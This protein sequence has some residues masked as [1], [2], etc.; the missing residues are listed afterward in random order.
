MPRPLFEIS[1]R[2]PDTAARTGMIHTTHGTIPTPAF[3]PV[4][5]QATVKSLAPKDLALLGVAIVMSNAY[6]LALRPGAATVEALGGLHALAGWDGP[7]MTDSGGFQ[8]FSLETKTQV[9]TDGVTFRSHID[10]SVQRF[11]PESV[12]AWQMTLGADLV[13]PLDVCTGYPVTH[14][15]A[16]AEMWLTRAWAERARRAHSRVGQVLYGIVQG[17]VFPDLRAESAR[18]IAAL[19]FEAY[20][21]GG[22]S[23]GETKTEMWSAVDAAL[24]HLPDAAPR[25]LLGV[26]YPEDL[27]EGVARGID[28]FDCVM[29]TRIARNAGALTMDGRI[30][31]RNSAFAQ[32]RRPL[33]E[34]CT[35]YACQHFSRG[36]IRHFT[37]ADEI[38]G[39]HLLTLHN[40]HFTL[41]LMRQLRGAIAAGSF[42][43]FR[44]DFLARYAG[45]AF[46]DPRGETPAP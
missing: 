7:M 16:A 28:T 2:D 10:G 22:V 36:A 40:L 14:E 45:G 42:A 6:H 29:P 17:S 46:Y 44:R 11:T 24:P 26:G 1:H 33:A 3:A 18:G 9:D 20:A 25:H 34:D 32:D 12:A 43:A 37:L 5:T 8:V 41:S 23:V 30:N 35:C 31:L 13:M 39:L 27:V 19:G 38:L 4:G 21:I 15:T